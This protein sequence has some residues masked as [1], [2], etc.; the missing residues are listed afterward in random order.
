MEQ[1]VSPADHAR[2]YS[3]EIYR[4]KQHAQLFH[5]AN[6]EKEVS[7][8]QLKTGKSHIHIPIKKLPVMLVF[9][10]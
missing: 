1:K 4:M 8:I 7:H 6:R 10:Y 5:T 9:P 2:G 3:Y